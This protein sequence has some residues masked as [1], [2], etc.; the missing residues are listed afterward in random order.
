MQRF[1]QIFGA[2]YLLVGLTGFVPPLLLGGLPPGVLGPLDGLQFGVF[3]VNWFHSLTH[4]AIGAIGLA[5]YR[6]PSA[7]RAYALALGVA[8]M[9]LFLL[10]FFTSAAAALGGLLP[11]N[12]ADDTLHLLTSLAAFVTYLMARLPERERGAA[13]PR[14]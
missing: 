8:Y 10:G 1:A 13:N 14:A 6:S 7:S 12:G 2:V 3:A 4:A 9:A 11:L 5:V